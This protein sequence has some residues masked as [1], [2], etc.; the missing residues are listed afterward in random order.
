MTTARMTG[1]TGIVAA[2]ALL[3]ASAAWSMPMGNQL[4][5]VKGLKN[6]GLVG[7]DN[8]G[9]LAYVTEKK[10]AE[11]V[12]NAINAERLKTYEKIAAEQKVSVEQVGKNRAA[13][14]VSEASSGEW[15]QDA[16]GTWQQK[17]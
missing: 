6:K 12:V 8:R 11:E 13:Q 3:L 10:V 5:I 1:W 4:A 15:Y 16:K 7:E 9:F 2:L 14:L 17:K